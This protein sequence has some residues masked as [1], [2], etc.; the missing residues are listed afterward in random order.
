[1]RNHRPVFERTSKDHA[2]RVV[3][4]ASLVLALAANTLA[5]PVSPQELADGE[6]QIWYLGH[7]GWAIQT[8]SRF[9]VFDY[10]VE[11]E[12]AE[13]RSLANGH[14]D[15]QEIEDLSVVVF[16]SHGVSTLLVKPR[17]QGYVLTPIGVP[18]WH[19]VS[20]AN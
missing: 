16:V 19:Y 5:G 17:V 8:K 14:I 4:G 6:A 7:S 2:P 1:M 9:L 11:S 12:P 10:T 15:P 3:L 20:L 13:P 18:Q